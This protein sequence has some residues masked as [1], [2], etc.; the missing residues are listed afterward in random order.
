MNRQ[1][2]ERVDQSLSKYER[3][4]KQMAMK[5]QIDLPMDD[6]LAEIVLDDLEP[7][8]LTKREVRKL[9]MDLRKAHQNKAI[10]EARALLPEQRQP[11]GQYL[12]FLRRKAEL[13]VVETARRLGIQR[14]YL[15]KIEA[16]LVNPVEIAPEKIADIIELF[17]IPFSEFVETVEASL[18]SAR[19][20]KTGQISAVAR[21]SS[22][23]GSEERG[24][25]VS[26]AIDAA[27]VEIARRKGE[28]PKESIQI[29]EEYLREIRE[30]LVKRDRA[31]L[32]V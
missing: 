27:L 15:E 8:E 23:P 21:S 29:S 22:W 7:V 17:R 28:I 1:D 4:L 16:A 5:G 13:T 2:K 10:E 31:D 32:L 26:Q 11:F 3:A 19:V 20:R 30:E 25:G 14:S 24:I 6:E 9:S 18:L 12:R